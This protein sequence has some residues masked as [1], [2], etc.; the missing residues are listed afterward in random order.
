MKWVSTIALLI[1][2][3]D[4]QISKVKRGMKKH[5]RQGYVEKTRSVC[6]CIFVNGI[7]SSPIDHIIYIKSI[8]SDNRKKAIREAAQF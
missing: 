8:R 2:N 6:T 7:F 1:I 3:S 4:R 5:T